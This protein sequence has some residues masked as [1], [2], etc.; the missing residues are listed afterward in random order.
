MGGEPRP[1]APNSRYTSKSSWLV[2]KALPRMFGQASTEWIDDNAQRLG[3]SVAFYTLLSPAPVLVIAVV[4][5]AVVFM[6]KRLPKGGLRRKSGA[7]PGP[8]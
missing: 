3:A 5:A 4:L 6:G 7:W 2:L 1:P 8:A